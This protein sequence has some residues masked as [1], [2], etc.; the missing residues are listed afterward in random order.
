VGDLVVAPLLV[1]W[2]V[3]P[4]LRWDRWQCLEATGL[5]VLLVFV[6]QAVFVGFFPSAFERYPLPYLTLPLLVWAAFRFGQ[7]AAATAVGILSGIALWGTLLDHGPFVAST[8]NE[9]L[10]L[11]QSFMG[12]IAVPT[13]ILAAV[14]AERQHAEAALRQAHNE[15]ERQVQQR[16]AQLA[17]ANQAL[18][19]E[20][21]ARQRSE[22][23]FRRLVETAG[24]LIVILRS[25]G[26][27]LYCSPFAE[28]LTGFR[29]EEVLG[30]NYLELCLPE[31][32]R[33]RAAAHLQ[34]VAAGEAL[35]SVETHLL[36]KD[37]AKHWM[38]WNAEP[39]TDYDGGPA[40]LAVGQDITAL[41][42]A[43]VRVLQVD[44]LAAMGQLM[45]GLV[46]KSRNALQR[47]QACLEMLLPAIQDR[48]RAL[49]LVAR[50]QNAQDHLHH[51]YETVRTYATPLQLHCQPCH[52]GTLLQEAWRQVMPVCHNPQ[53]RLHESAAQPDLRCTADP[54]VLQQVFRN[55]LENALD[56]AHGPIEI[57]VTWS[58]ERLNGQPAIRLSIQDTG[59]G[60]TPEQ[61]LRVFEPFFTTK[62]QGTGLGLAIARRIVEAHGGRI[63]L[64]DG[65]G[66]G[67]E[68][69]MTLPRGNL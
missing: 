28:A 9:S 35:R 64:G 31:A 45:N 16:T 67:A 59:P 46:H 37:G 66:P 69:I 44:R 26:C 10:L 27:I 68:F 14:V 21:G 15:L 65:A 57:R 23:H 6:G 60:L 20:I 22:A 52:L 38:V 62:T 1:L 2:S 11:L 34:Q 61:R 18:R 25:D 42:E 56:A 7:R 3:H 40:I 58:E 19:T 41:K 5:L 32:D 30:Q 55:L 29:S 43:Q 33:P 50:L 48:P 39:L 49:N 36:R 17:G 12:V 51:I 8:P 53:V 63:A 4:R 13:M 24:C 47:S 54:H